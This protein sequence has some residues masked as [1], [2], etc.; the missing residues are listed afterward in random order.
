MLLMIASDNDPFLHN[1]MDLTNKGEG[2][3]H[4]GKGNRA[5]LMGFDIGDKAAGR[6]MQKHD[7]V[8]LMACRSQR[9]G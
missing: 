4:D 7:W 6:R 2:V 3:E 1:D 5:S 9:A 8:N